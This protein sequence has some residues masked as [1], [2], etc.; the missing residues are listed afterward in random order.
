LLF[1]IHYPI[2]FSAANLKAGS[3]TRDCNQN[4]R[5]GI[6]GGLSLGS[7]T[8]AGRNMS[9]YISNLFDYYF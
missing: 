1:F 3:L 7:G 2:K 6:Y 9:K 4:L 8:L 5:F